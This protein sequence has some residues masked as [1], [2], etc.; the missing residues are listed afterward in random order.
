[1]SIVPLSTHAVALFKRAVELSNGSRYVF[2]A[3]TLRVRKGKE[4]RM[5]HIHGESVSRAMA[6][7]RERLGLDDAH[8]H[9][10]RK[11]VTT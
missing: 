11:T 5:P 10:L 9:D 3:D 2:P 7:L 6:R 8:V 4:A 1:V